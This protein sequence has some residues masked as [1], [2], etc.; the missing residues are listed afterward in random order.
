MD[1]NPSARYKRPIEIYIELLYTEMFVSGEVAGVPY[2]PMILEKY[3]Q[4]RRGILLNG[5]DSTR[6]FLHYQVR[7]A[8]CLNP[9]SFTLSIVTL[10]VISQAKSIGKVLLHGRAPPSN[11]APLKVQDVS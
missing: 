7:P 4:Y 5:N 2:N 10:M 11:L 6:H 3:I 8:S 9:E 1:S